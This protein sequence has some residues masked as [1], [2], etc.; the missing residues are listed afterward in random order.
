MNKIVGLA[1]FGL[2][3]LSCKSQKNGSEETFTIAFGSCNKQYEENTLW[4]DVL[5]YKPDVW[6]WGGDNI[7]S[8]TDEA[9]KMKS[10]YEAQLKQKGYEEL[11]H[12]TTVI[13]TWDDHDYG[14]ND[15]GAEFK[16][17]KESQQL[18]LDFLGVDKTDVRREREGVYSSET[19]RFKTGSVRIIILDTRYFR[20][21]LTPDNESKK[22]FKPNVYGEGTI[23]GNAQWNWLEKELKNSEADFNIIMSSIQVLSD[24]H[25]FETWGNFPHE[26][27]RLINLI[28]ESSARGVIILSG[29]RH[30]SEFSKI[31]LDGQPLVD[32][33]SSGLTHTYTSYKGEENPYRYGKVIKDKSFGILELDFKSRK[34]NMI[35]AG[36]GNK[37]LQ[38]ITESY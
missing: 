23:L 30:I 19:Y 4:D 2:I 13:G 5:L 17:K 25:G 38:K 9:E 34:V 33:T 10:D 12:S 6:I 1:C 11:A 35:M 24:K 32:F 7:Y 3:I 37:V 16:M 26:R 20:T 18:F 15:G 36:D 8:D 21:S 31:D 22:R 28:K 14:I 29:D 27:D